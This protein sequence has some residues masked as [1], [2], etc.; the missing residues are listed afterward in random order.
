ML[1]K[2][3]ATDVSIPTVY[4][5]SL[6]LEIA[7]EVLQ[8]KVEPT[9]NKIASLCSENA[10]R[11]GLGPCVSGCSLDAPAMTSAVGKICAQ[12]PG[13][14]QPSQRYPTMSDLGKGLCLMFHRK[15]T[16]EV[17]HGETETPSGLPLPHST[18]CLLNS[19]FFFLAALG[20]S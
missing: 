6:A 14:T 15:S 5:A 10:D 2:L 16:E 1:G 20:L 17:H 18:G 12:S 4:P 11:L 9:K 7:S 13:E 3:W 8:P 19:V